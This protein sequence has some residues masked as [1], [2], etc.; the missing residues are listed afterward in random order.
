MRLPFFKGATCPCCSAR[1]KK[2]NSTTL[3]KFINTLFDAYPN[4]VEFWYAND[5][6]RAYRQYTSSEKRLPCDNCLSKGVALAANVLEQKFMDWPPF[7]AYYDEVRVCAIC[8]SK[9][10]FTKEEKIYWFENLKFW[11][12]DDSVSCHSCRNIKKQR[13]EAQKTLEKLIPNLNIKTIEELEQAIALYRFT[14]SHKK[15]E[16]YSKILSKL[17]K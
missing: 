7:F 14:D 15:I 6:Q 9:F 13:K 17:R 10:T 11:V 4:W 8:D 12:T 3:Q 16:F 1:I 2:K 5:R